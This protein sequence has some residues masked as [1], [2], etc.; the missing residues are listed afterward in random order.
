M[1]WADVDFEKGTLR[2]N[3]TLTTKIKGEKYTISP[4]KT[5][6]SI[7][8]LPLTKKIIEGLKIMHNNAI[9]FMDFSNE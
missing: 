6:S 7:R 3:K 2:I 4:P 8:T 1:N 9:K 5:K